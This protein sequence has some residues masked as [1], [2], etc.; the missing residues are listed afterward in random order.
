MAKVG[1]SLI[2]LTHEY[3]P[4]VFGGVAY[5]SQQ[6]AKW[7][8][9]RGWKVYVIA[10]RAGRKERATVHQGG[11]IVEVRI[12]FPDIPPRWVFFVKF[13]ERF[14][15]MLLQKG[16]RLVLSNSPLTGFLHILENV[17]ITTVYHGTSYA[18]LPFFKTM[19]ALKSAK[20]G[21]IPLYFSYPVLRSWIRRDLIRSDFNIFVARH[22]RL[23]AESLYPELAPKIRQFG[24]VAYPGI[25]CRL[26][27]DIKRY[28]PRRKRMKLVIAFVGRLYYNKGVTYA[29]ETVE[30][31]I[32]KG[33]KDVELWVFGT[34]PLQRWVA[35][36]SKQLP[37]RYFGFVERSKLLSLL[38]H[39]VDV[40][41]HPSLYEA[42][43]MALVEAQALGIP[44]ITF[45][46]PWAH[47]FVINGVNG[48]R[49]PYP[50]VERL[51]EMV[52]K[53]TELDPGKVALSAKRFDRETAFR[54]VES[55]L[56]KMGYG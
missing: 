8:A 3:P 38:A 48:Y 7:L 23:E 32:K 5:Y 9:D 14:V 17:K 50:D 35:M 13:A 25:D 40:L 45:D 47:E 2:L 4:Y 20:P 29:L 11:N 34:G 54:V 56:E 46:L 6:L 39:Y 51:G 55:I 19:D 28:E 21:E 12:Y 43:P 10:G 37:I 24:A 22:V 53:A 30:N 27:C 41:L 18:L 36:K 42:A 26:L 16:I 1:K 44:T 52:L 33:E 15:G 31:L 49:A